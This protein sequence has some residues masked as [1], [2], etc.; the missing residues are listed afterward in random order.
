MKHPSNHTEYQCSDQEEVDN[1]VHLFPSEA[2]QNQVQEYRNRQGE[3]DSVLQP[4]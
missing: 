3:I 4:E 1:R 2:R